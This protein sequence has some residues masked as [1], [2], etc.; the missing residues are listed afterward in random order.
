MSNKEKKLFAH[1][2]TNLLQKI[3]EIYLLLIAEQRAAHPEY[4]N[5]E[6]DQARQF[7]LGDILFSSVQVQ[8]KAK[9]GAVAKLGLDEKNYDLECPPV[10][11]ESE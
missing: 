7:K 9:T 8:S 5:A 1:N 10:D 2:L 3:W 4:R 11:E 6:T